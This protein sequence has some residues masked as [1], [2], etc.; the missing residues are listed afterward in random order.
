MN[1]TSIIIICAVYLFVEGFFNQFHKFTSYRFFDFDN[2]K[3]NRNLHILFSL[4]F[5]II[6]LLLGCYS[7]LHEGSDISS[8]AIYPMFFVGIAGLLFA[9][10]GNKFRTRDYQ[11][12]LIILKR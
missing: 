9:Y 1:T 7:V 12:I 8:D 10:M 4:I 6:L 11:S 5:G 2:F 3:R